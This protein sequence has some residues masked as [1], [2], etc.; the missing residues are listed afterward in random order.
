MVGIKSITAS[1]TLT[2]D[3]NIL[4]ESVSAT[5]DTTLPFVRL[6]PSACTVFEKAFGLIWNDDKDLYLINQTSH[7]QLLNSNPSITF[8]LANQASGSTTNVT[9]PYSA[10]DLQASNPIFPN[11]TNY[12]PLKRASTPTEYMLGR[13]FL[14]EAFVFVDYEQK[15]FSISQTQFPTNVSPTLVT[16]DHSLQASKSSQDQRSLSHGAIAGVVIGSSVA[17]VL[18]CALALLQFRR[19][20]RRQ[21]KQRQQV[22]QNATLTS[23]LPPGKESW[24]SSPSNSSGPENPS[25][26]GGLTM[27][28]S[29][30]D[31]DPEKPVGE[32]EDPMTAVTAPSIHW[33][34]PNRP[35]QELQGSDTAKELPP[36][37]RESRRHVY[38]LANSDVRSEKS[39][40]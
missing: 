8:T 36:T 10:F 25:T 4:S 40:R 14:Q 29:S 1:G 30:L 3:V 9:L 20:R 28:E 6:P 24:P 38:E 37:P 34:S 21:Q 26:P 16:V 17:F 11:G 12:F 31:R 35:R 23:S 22:R 7:T 33:P 2:K 13:T 19:Y 5:I 32:L 18:L 27:A 39:R 15:N